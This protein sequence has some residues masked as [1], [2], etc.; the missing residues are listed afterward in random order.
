MCFF[1]TK[2]LIVGESVKKTLQK[3][4]HKLKKKNKKAIS[5]GMEI[6]QKI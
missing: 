5:L 3:R 1:M 4:H 2:Y 6:V